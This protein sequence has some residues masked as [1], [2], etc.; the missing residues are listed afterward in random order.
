M[1][2]PHGCS[3]R[4]HDPERKLRMTNKLP[5]IDYIRN[6][7]SYDKY[8]GVLTWADNARGRNGREA[9]AS[10]MNGG[11]RQGMVGGVMMLAHRVIWAHQFGEWPPHQ[12]DHI[13]GIRDD[14]RLDNLRSVTRRENQRNLKL[15]AKN[16]SGIP[17][18]YYIKKS[19][20][21]DCRIGVNGKT[22]CLGTH[23]CFGAAIRARLG[24][25][26]ELGYTFRSII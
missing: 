6:V 26:R 7:L 14:N 13:N 21:W 3:R 25:M 9:F 20:K 2:A 4:S 16:K 22:K 1:K 17:G 10:K 15:N 24:A 18:I 12:I 8:T 11:Y 23:A 19:G 5:S